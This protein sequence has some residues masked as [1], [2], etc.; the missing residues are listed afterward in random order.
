MHSPNLG[1]ACAPLT[2]L[3]GVPLSNVSEVLDDIYVLVQLVHL[4]LHADLVLLQYSFKSAVYQTTWC[5]LHGKLHKQKPTHNMYVV[6][7]K[8]QMK[9]ALSKSWCQLLCLGMM[10][11]GSRHRQTSVLVEQLKVCI[12]QRG[13]HLVSSLLLQHFHCLPMCQL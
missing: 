7:S 6:I 2:Q 11:L 3:A 9:R 1:K 4:C 12:L 10:R 5:C 8:S 13:L